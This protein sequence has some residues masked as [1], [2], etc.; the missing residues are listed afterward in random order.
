[1][2]AQALADGV[3]VDVSELAHE[4]GFKLPVAVSDTLYHGYLMPPLDL[5]KAGLSF[6]GRLWD[7]LSVLRYAIKS[8]SATDRLSFTVL[9]AQASDATPVSV[10][11]LAVCGPGDSGE[12]VITIMLPSDD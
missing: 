12:P 9:F 8:A 7:T 1:S 4:A 2:R 10:N 3:L 6:E 5:V 11:L